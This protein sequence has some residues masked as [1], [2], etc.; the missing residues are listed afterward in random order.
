[1]VD[2]EYR[3]ERWDAYKLGLKHAKQRIA[4]EDYLM[5]ERIRKSYMDGYVKGVENRNK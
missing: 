4:R 5:P 3:K 2:W 1:M